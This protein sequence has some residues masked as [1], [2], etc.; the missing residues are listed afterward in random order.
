MTIIYELLRRYAAGERAFADA[1]LRGAQLAGV[2]LSGIRLRGADLRGATID[3][4]DFYLVDLRDAHYDDE[5][6]AHFRACGAL[7][8][9]R[10]R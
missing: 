10:C 6:A 2:V 7:L 4:V 1:D 5:Q 8:H 3:G 9:D